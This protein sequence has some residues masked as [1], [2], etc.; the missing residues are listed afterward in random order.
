[1]TYTMYIADYGPNLTDYKTGAPDVD[2]YYEALNKLPPQ[3][4][5]T[6]NLR[7]PYETPV[8]DENWC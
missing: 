5:D 2:A 8:V 3:V 7:Y 4:H 6:A 1:M